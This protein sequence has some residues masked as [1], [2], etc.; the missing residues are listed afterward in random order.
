[1][2]HVLDLLLRLFL[3]LDLG[4]LSVAIFNISKE[5]VCTIRKLV[6]TGPVPTVLPP[7]SLCNFLMEGGDIKTKQDIFSFILYSI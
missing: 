4:Q 3:I 5:H 7:A 1:M 6:R 2:Q